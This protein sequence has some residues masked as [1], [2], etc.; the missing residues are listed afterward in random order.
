MNA[1]A[2]RPAFHRRAAVPFVLVS[3]GLDTLSMCMLMPVFAPLVQQFEHG[4]AASAGRVIGVLAAAW[5]VA[6]FFGA[7]IMGALADRFGRRPVLLASIF[8]LGLETLLMAFAPNLTWLF[9]G[10]LLSGFTASSFLVATAYIADVTPPEQR[11]ARFGLVGAIWNVAMIVGPA[12]GGLLGAVNLRLPFFISAGVCLVAAVYGYFVLPESLK[13][14]SRTPYAWSKANPIA[15]LSFLGSH[16][17]LLWLSVVNFLMQFAYAVIPTLFILYAGNRYGWSLEVTGLA[18]AATGVFGVIVQA[19]VARR[20]FQR[21]GELRAMILGLTATAVALTVYGLAP[22]GWIFLI[23]TPIAALLGLFTPG[24]QALSS[25][26]VA[27]SEQ[28]RLQGANSAVTGLASM[29]APATFGSIYAASAQGHGAAGAGA[30]AA[31]LV[32]AA[33]LG[34]AA[35]V[36]AVAVAP[37]GRA[38]PELRRIP[39]AAARAFSQL[40]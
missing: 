39:A 23:G 27:A 40:R 37:Q 9:I 33:L 16:P 8:G 11:A 30:G 34:L 17:E 12:L 29:I 35:L 4:D 15:S 20:L 19:G 31:F 14:G 13:P 3:L 24:F 28:G 18:L 5:A 21:I 6:Q 32:A 25:R 10:R 22:A 36:A 26:R 2:V 7:P 38:R 1:F